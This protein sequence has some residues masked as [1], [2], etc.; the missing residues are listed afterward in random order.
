MSVKIREKQKANGEIALYLDI[1]YKGN[2]Q[3][4]FLDLFLTKDREK[5]KE[6]RRLAEDIRAK[7]QLEL[8][9]NHYQ[10]TPEFKSKV[11]F[12][13]YFDAVGQRSKH[14][15]WKS[16][17]HHIKAFAGSNVPF[18]SIDEKWLMGFQ[19]YLLNVV[20]T[21]TAIT[22]FNKVKASLNLATKEKLIRNNPA[23][24]IANIREK[25]TEKV[26]LSLNEIKLLN[27]T[28]LGNDTVKRAFLF[29]CFTGLRLSDVRRLEWKHVQDD[30]LT[31]RIKKTRQPEYLPLSQAAK[32]ILGV[33]GPDTEKV[34][35]MMASDGGVWTTLQ[36]WREKAGLEKH[37]SFHV[38][39]HTFATLALTSGIDLYTVSKLLGHSSIKN[40]QIYA[41]IV[42]QKKKDAVNLLPE[43]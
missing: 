23:E 22:Y 10:I 30:Q 3:Y 28:P 18:Q 38:S 36:R 40:T 33:R 1:Y 13:E 31:L 16:T 8:S 26:F 15:N 42:D 9:A 32:R 39:R 25:P 35:K 6:V 20:D 12:I 4:E 17:L 43:I 34:F 27:E 7:R 19:T 11:N 14:R 5:N 29:S 37:I 2:R 41:K 21:N 24:Y